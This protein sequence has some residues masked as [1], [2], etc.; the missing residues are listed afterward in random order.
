MPA[1]HFRHSTGVLLSHQ[2]TSPFPDEHSFRLENGQI[3]E[4]LGFGSSGYVT[5]PSRNPPSGSVTTLH[6]VHGETFTDA[7]MTAIANLLSL[8]R[9]RYNTASIWVADGIPHAPEITRWVSGGCIPGRT[10]AG[11]ETSTSPD[12]ALTIEEQAA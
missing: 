7:D 5:P 4:L 12:D 1:A 10:D 2:Q 11:W 3:T 8:H 6:Y 9:S